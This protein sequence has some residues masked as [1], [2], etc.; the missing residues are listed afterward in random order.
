M[1]NNSSNCEIK[2]NK[3]IYINLFYSS[4]QCSNSKFSKN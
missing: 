4:N 3:Y 1:D 2:C